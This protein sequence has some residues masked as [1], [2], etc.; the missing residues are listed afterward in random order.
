MKHK[1]KKDNNFTDNTENIRQWR[2]NFIFNRRTA[3]REQKKSEIEQE[4]AEI[5]E[6]KRQAA[7]DKK[8]PLTV[9][10]KSFYR[11]SK[12]FPNNVD[13]KGFRENGIISKKRR[14][15]IIWGTLA[16]CILAF[17]CAFTLS[18][19]GIELSM[20]EPSTTAQATENTENTSSF[21]AYHFTY[22]D[23]YEADTE[24]MKS[25][26]KKADCNTAVFEYK[27]EHGYVIF[28]SKTVIGASA[29]KRLSSAVKTVQTLSEAGIKTAAYISCFKDTVAA[30]GDL[31][32]S[33]RQTSSEGGAWR[34]NSDNGWLNPFSQNT[35]DYILTLVEEAAQTGF[36]YIFLDNVCFSTDAGN[37]K[38]YYTDESTSKYNRNTVLQAFIKSCQAK[39]QKSKVIVMCDISAYN[40]RTVS[41]GKYAGNLLSLGSEN[42]AVD[43]RLSK[44]PKTVKIGSYEFSLVKEL[45]YVFVLDA[46]EYAA[47]ELTAAEST[48]KDAFIVLENSDSL[49]EQISAAEFSGFT[50]IIIW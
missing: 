49:E 5:F 28:P 18:K 25:A 19:A 32:Y 14:K 50:N 13:D 2:K 47:Q 17:C 3:L 23:L 4:K 26:L 42:L 48:P 41:D 30:V 10:T 43:L 12:D 45:P 15:F 34:D 46:S 7:S 29:N 22:D 35:T 31:S 9:K 36:D 6:K 11:F 24:K 16:V 33:V 39:A 8:A 1:K 38:A 40:S 20:K 21:S 37:A 44:Q 27:T